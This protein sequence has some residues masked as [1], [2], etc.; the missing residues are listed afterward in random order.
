MNEFTC[1]D[2]A[3]R[4]FLMQWAGYCLTG[5]MR[6]QCLGF[7]FGDG[8]NGKTVF[9]QLL[10]S[11]LK[12][13]AMNAA[14][15]LFVTTSI[16]K[17]ATGFADLHRR[18]CVIA[19]ETQE[20][21]TLRM[22]KIK[23]ITGQDWMRAN[24]MRRDNFEFL[25]VCK[26]NMFGNHK[27]TLPDVGKAVRKRI[28]LVPCNFRLKVEEIDRNLGVK[29]MNEG[30]GILRAMIDGCRDW[31][32]NG[33]MVPECVEEQTENY[34]NAQDTVGKWFEECCEEHA[35]AK[36]SSAYVWRSWAVWAGN[37]KLKIGTDVELS[38][39]LEARGFKKIAHVE[40]PDGKRPR[41]WE[42]FRL[43]EKQIEML[44]YGPEPPPHTRYR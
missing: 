29:L 8:D 3:L 34:F 40:M 20:G 11:L 37:Q 19:N 27:P 21:Q 33:L 22:D 13:Y 4:R 24:F 7:Y 26:I 36:V 38:E 23:Q 28:R 6:E 17:H 5:D 2:D 16:G 39:K 41:G 25:P 30:P 31:Q 18:R 32:D 15:D 1:G 10:R 14:V 12:D 35:N 44:D 43:Q 42:G 9:I